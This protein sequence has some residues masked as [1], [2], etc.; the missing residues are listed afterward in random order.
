MQIS[1][2]QTSTEWLRNTS[3][4]L[5]EAKQ[6]DEALGYANQ[7]IVL[8]PAEYH[9][10]WQKA[11]CLMAKNDFD[12]AEQALIAGAQL[13]GPYYAHHHIHSRILAKAGRFEEAVEAERRSLQNFPDYFESLFN[14]ACL[15]SE[16]RSY[17]E[18]LE[19]FNRALRVAGP[20]AN[21]VK[22]KIDEL[23]ATLG[24]EPN[25][26]TS[27]ATV[28]WGPRVIG[29]NTSG[30]NLTEIEALGYSHNSGGLNNQKFA[31]L[32]LITDAYE[33]KRPILLPKM[34][35]KDHVADTYTPV[36][37]GEVFDLAPLFDLLKKY[38]ITVIEGNADDFPSD[39]SWPYFSKGATKCA[40]CV[41]GEIKD[42]VLAGLVADYF[43]C[44]TPVVKNSYIMKN[45]IE[46]V[47][48][49]NGIEVVAQFRIESDWLK[50]CE[51]NLQHTL[52]DPEDYNLTYDQIVAKIVRTLPTVKKILVLCDEAAVSIPKSQ[53]ADV[54][55]TRF[56]VELFWKSDFLT[57]FE[58]TKLNNLELSMIDFELALCSKHYV[59]MTR[60]TF[61]N[62]VTS[63]KYMITGKPVTGDY[64]YN[65]YGPSLA[66]RT[67]NGGSD[68]P[69]RNF[70]NFE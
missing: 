6:V 34:I 7:A 47:F 29:E 9:N 52:T 36:S 11:E 10:Y 41:K 44:L 39:I 64:I 17:E 40:Q 13:G 21:Y 49:R 60:S 3:K 59:G 1:E 56:G 70:S 23:T 57:R 25:G 5:L 53:M 48:T 62:T 32:G 61:S 68:V 18:A 15:L 45:L 33:K 43:R 65:N 46:E 35:I 24:S 12:G 50:H 37:I 55:R 66:R 19:T 51:Y 54:C 4:A 2:T 20:H 67:D 14:M 63:T 22:S 42:S 38:R 69:P 27:I 16:L 58:L 30:E 31:L 8:G 26:D 28:L